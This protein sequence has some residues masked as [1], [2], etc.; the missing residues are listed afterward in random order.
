[1]LKSI[2]EGPIVIFG[3]RP[4]E[5]TLWKRNDHAGSDWSD[6]IMRDNIPID[7]IECLP[8]D[9]QDV[10]PPKL[11]KGKPDLFLQ[12]PTLD[13][14]RII[15]WSKGTHFDSTGLRKCTVRSPSENPQIKSWYMGPQVIIFDDCTPLLPNVADCYPTSPPAF[16]DLYFYFSFWCLV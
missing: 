8:R 13:H 3:C 15:R 2:L 11:R 9:E 16:I 1:M 12:E 4:R 10:S 7:W 5:V 6:G 14:R